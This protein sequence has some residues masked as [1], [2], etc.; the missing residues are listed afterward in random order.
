M[1][2]VVCPHCNAVNRVPADKPAAQGKCGRCHKPLFDGHPGLGFSRRVSMRRF[3]RAIFPLSSISG[4][5]GAGPVRPWRPI[6]SRS[7]TNLSRI[8]LPQGRYRGSAGASRALQIRS[9]PT[10]MVFHNGAISRSRR[11]RWMRTACEA[12]SSRWRGNTSISLRRAQARGGCH[13]SAGR[14]G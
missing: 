2:H 7:P 10:L 1:S 12:G 5:N 14:V 13:A 9:I 8:S 6:S 3:R 11:V 4:P